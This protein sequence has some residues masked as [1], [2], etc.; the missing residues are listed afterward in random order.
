MFE[1]IYQQHWMALPKNVRHHLVE[2][3]DIKRSGITEI[4]DQ[5]VIS[6]GTT[7]ND[8]GEITLEKLNEYIGSVETFPRAWEI[9]LMKVHSELNPPTI[10]IGVGTIEK[11]LPEIKEELNEESIKTKKSK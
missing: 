3:F 4:R 10:E 6:D 2:I 5:E 7:N 11:E 9:T 1:R 8:L